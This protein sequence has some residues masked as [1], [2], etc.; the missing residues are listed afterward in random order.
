MDNVCK[1]K[2]MKSES[3]PLPV[4][5]YSLGIKAGHF[6]F[7]S[8]QL[9][10]DSLSNQLA[11]G[12]IEAQT[13]RALENLKT[14][15][16]DAGC[17]LSDVVKTTVFLKDINDFASMNKVYTEFFNQDPPARSAMQVAALPKDG[18]VEIE[19]IAFDAHDYDRD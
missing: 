14:I 6:I 1:K 2:T 18:M 8:G 16:N 5:P 4:G 13:R 7:L 17:K 10:L 3:V 9:G 11:E 15:L 19:A 12:G